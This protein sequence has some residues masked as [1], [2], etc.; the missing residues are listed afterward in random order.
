MAEGRRSRG[1]QRISAD[2]RVISRELDQS[3]MTAD[4]GGEKQFED[5][6]QKKEEMEESRERSER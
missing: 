1:E 5:E 6:E 3:M 4:D 2:K